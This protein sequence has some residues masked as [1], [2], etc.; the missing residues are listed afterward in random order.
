MRSGTCRRSR[1]VVIVG[2]FAGSLLTAIAPP[3]TA[4]P[5]DTTRISVSTEGVEAE[6]SSRPG[7]ISDDGRFVAFESSATKLASG[8]SSSRT[9]IFVRDV[10]SGKTQ[11]VSVSSSGG[12]GNGSSFSPSLSSDGRYVAFAS[13]ATNLVPNDFNG[14]TD[15]FV[16]DRKENTMQLVS[17]SSLE[18]ASNGPSEHPSISDDGSIVAFESRADNLAI[19]DLNRVRDIFVRDL[20]AG[21]TERVSLSPSGIDG[22]AQSS[23]A[24]VSGDGSH[25]AFESF[26]SNLVA[27]DD[28]NTLDVFVAVVETGAISRASVNSDEVPANGWSQEPTMSDDGTRVAFTSWATNLV[29]DDVTGSWDDVFVRD[30][31]NGTTILASGSSDVQAN[32]HSWQPSL[33]GDGRYVAFSTNATNLVADDP[34]RRS[35]DADV[36]MRD[37]ETGVVRRISISST[38]EGANGLSWYPRVA[39]GGVAVAFESSATNLVADDHNNVQ[40][41]FLHEVVLDAGPLIEFTADSDD[42]GTFSDVATIRAR[43]MTA[44]RAPLAG[45]EVL[46]ELTG[47][48]QQAWTATSDADGIAGGDID[49]DLS[50]GTYRLVASYAGNAQL[51]RPVSATM[52]FTIVEERTLLRL[53]VDGRG[54]RRAL[55]ATLLEDDPDV[56]RAVAGQSLDFYADGRWIGSAT[57]GADGRAIF[58][59]PPRFQGGRHVF[60]GVY[61]DESSPYYEG[62]S[63]T[64]SS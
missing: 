23:H 9:Q 58:D 54:A 37:L 11:L 5:G 19:P 26:A 45:Q 50:P 38:G 24:A 46:F 8:T 20:V 28:A 22:N 35:D 13:D 64:A 31:E 3:A 59:V 4:A 41:V 30:L 48:S 40:D 61:E 34:P 33:S 29:T 17:V 63:A 27:D 36:Y 7:S 6:R 56:E 15:I 51:R 47:P 43:I 25:V 55:V 57:T 1:A 21:T 62:S 18:V 44:E 39:D 2:L 12:G 53:V 16:R 14:S 42:R 32:A 49:L 60:T 10:A 52:P